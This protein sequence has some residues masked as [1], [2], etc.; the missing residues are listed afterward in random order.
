V[1]IQEGVEGYIL[2]WYESKLSRFTSFY[3]CQHF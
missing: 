1:R 2:C 3:T